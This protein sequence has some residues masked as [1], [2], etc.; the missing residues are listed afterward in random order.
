MFCCSLVQDGVVCTVEMCKKDE[1][2]VNKEKRG[3]PAKIVKVIPIGTFNS[4]GNET[5]QKELL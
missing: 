5:T 3:Y 1:L 2:W 4:Y